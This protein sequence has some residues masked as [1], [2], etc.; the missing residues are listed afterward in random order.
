MPEAPD[1]MLTYYRYPLTHLGYYPEKSIRIPPALETMYCCINAGIHTACKSSPVIVGNT[2]Y[3]GS[4]DGTMYAIDK[5]S[6]K[7]IWKYKVRPEAA[8][9]IHGTA[10]IRGGSL[11]IGAYDGYLY[12]LN[13]FSGELLREIKLGD[14]IGSSPVIWKNRVYIGVETSEPNGY[15]S[16][17]DLDTWTIRF[18]TRAMG[19]VTH[20]TPAIDEKTGL[21]FLGASSDWFFAF[22]ADSGALKWKH[23]TGR[24]IKSTAAIAGA[25]V[26]V[27]SWDG[28]LYALDKRK[29]RVVWK[30]RTGDSSMSSPAVDPVEGR[31]YFGSHDAFLHCVRLDDGRP[32]WKY[33]TGGK[34]VSSPV[35]VS[36]SRDDRKVLLFGSC[37]GHLYWVY[38]DDGSPAHRHAT[39][40]EVTCVPLVHEGKVYVSG[41]DGFLY[42]F[43]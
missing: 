9:G 1:R 32:L 40:G 20:C 37:D 11:F 18:Q 19:D 26:L 31:V 29:G 10:A 15:L 42:V 30:Y 2:L 6:M 36:S 13:R 21:V 7:V 35:L 34:I 22:D 28:H 17:V 39:Q 4:D 5:A 14:Y 12:E 41:A 24:D 16:C 43:R 8:Y 27:T 3:V 38:A 23:R 25:L 33:G